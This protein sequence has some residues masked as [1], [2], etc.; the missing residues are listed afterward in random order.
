MANKDWIEPTP[1]QVRQVRDAMGLTQAELGRLLHA[2]H[3]TA[4]AWELGERRMPLATWEL[5]VLKAR[6][7]RRCPVDID[8]TCPPTPTML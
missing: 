4:V 8:A 2:A 5:L 1:Q 6:H 3:R 7:M